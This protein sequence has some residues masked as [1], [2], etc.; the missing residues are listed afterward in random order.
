MKTQAE[1]RADV[2]RL[3]D[4]DMVEEAEAVLE[5]LKPL[6]DEGVAALPRERPG[7]R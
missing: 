7:R 5:Q 6:S 4:E 1:L 2:L 3:L